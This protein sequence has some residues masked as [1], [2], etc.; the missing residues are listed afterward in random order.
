MK[1]ITFWPVWIHPVRMCPFVE[2]NMKV[3]RHEFHSIMNIA[4][5]YLRVFLSSLLSFSCLL[6]FCFFFLIPCASLLYIRPPRACMKA[7]RRHLFFQ[8]TRI[9]IN[10]INGPVA[11]TAS[12]TFTAPEE[13]AKCVT[14]ANSIS[15]YRHIH[16][17][18]RW[19]TKLPYFLP[20]YL[21]LQQH[22]EE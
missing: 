21:C 15:S 1:L 20:P 22:C 14:D 8:K 13:Y 5:G 2:S 12:V 3:H 6:T 4:A 18:V 10:K 16:R 7:L 9:T 17:L 19:W 11:T